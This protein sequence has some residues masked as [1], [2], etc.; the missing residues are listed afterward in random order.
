MLDKGYSKKTIARYE[1]NLYSLCHEIPKD[2]FPPESDK[3]L[4]DFMNQP[5]SGIIDKFCT[6]KTSF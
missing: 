2:D 6:D 3:T 4:K 1:C 5:V